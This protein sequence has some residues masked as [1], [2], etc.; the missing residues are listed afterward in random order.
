[1]TQ[2]KYVYTLFLLFGL[3]K[4][5]DGITYYDYDPIFIYLR[6]GSATPHMIVNSGLGGPECGFHKNEIRPATGERS[7]FEVLFSAKM[8]PK[9]YYPF[10]KDGSLPSDSFYLRGIE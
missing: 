8:C 10:G 6:E 7:G 2:E 3:S 9:P 5:Y 4:L 1:M